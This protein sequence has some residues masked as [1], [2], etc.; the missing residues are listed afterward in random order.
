M[1]TTKEDAYGVLMA[2]RTYPALE[3]TSKTP[4]PAAVDS[5]DDN[6]PQKLREQLANSLQELFPFLSLQEHGKDKS[7]LF[8][9]YVD[10]LVD[11]ERCREEALQLTKAMMDTSIEL[12]SFEETPA[13]YQEAIL[14]LLKKSGEVSISAPE[15]LATAEMAT[16]EPAEILVQLQACLK[17]S[18]NMLVAEL[19]DAFDSLVDRSGAGLV[20]WTSSNTV[21]YHFFRRVLKKDDPKLPDSQSTFNTCSLAHH[22]HDLIDAIQ[23]SLDN[24]TVTIPPFVKKLVDTIPPWMQSSICIVEGYLINERIYESKLF[25]TELTDC[26]IYF[27]DLGDALVEHVPLGHGYDPA[28]CLGP[29]VLVGWGPREIGVEQQRKK[30]EVAQRTEQQ[31]ARFWGFSAV[32]GQAFCALFAHL[33][34]SL[35]SVLLFVVSIACI[36]QWVSRASQEHLSEWKRQRIGLG[37]MAFLGGLQLLLTPLS[38]WLVL[39]GIGLLIVG[40]GVL[41]IDRGVLLRSFNSRG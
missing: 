35:L 6:S 33:G 28:V 8:A 11:L 18:I 20:H 25:S 5:I 24:S 29:Y 13:D 9:Q 39:A 27:S 21:K 19:F 15:N 16:L 17:G 34:F 14:D 7:K 3:S 4:V 36:T 41:C 30:T 1:P 2:N 10:S 22:K 12:S 26:T 31:N 32:A 23:T 38:F 40:T 37:F